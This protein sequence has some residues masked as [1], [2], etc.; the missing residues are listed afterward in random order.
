MKRRPFVRR[1]K[2][3]RGMRRILEVDLHEGGDGGLF[4][5]AEGAAIA[6]TAIF[7][8]PARFDIADADFEQHG[9]DAAL[10]GR[11]QDRQDEAAT[12]ALPCIVRIDDHALEFGRAIGKV[13]KCGAANCDTIEPGH[14]EQ[15]AGSIETAPVDR[16]AI[17]AGIQA[18]GDGIGHL[19]QS[20]N[21]RLIR[22][23]N[24]D[25]AGLWAML[26][27]ARSDL[28]N[29]ASDDHLGTFLIVQGRDEFHELVHLT[30]LCCLTESE[31]I[32]GG[33]I[34]GSQQFIDE[35]ARSRPK[36]PSGK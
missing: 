36:I 9:A 17:F 10:L 6:E 16:S 30:L 27:H 35:G 8:E 25:Q 28:L 3:Y 19:Q 5:A 31:Q 11:V 22:R 2:W 21:I 20:I 4:V 32:C 29:R 1:D 7:V 33:H 12:D 26:P 23:L 15:R 14:E 18:L 34:K 13:E 24:G